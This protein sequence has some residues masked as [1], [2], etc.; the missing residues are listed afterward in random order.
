MKKRWFP[1]LSAL[2]LWCMFFA[3]AY[4]RAD[5]GMNSERYGA[6]ESLVVW[7]EGIMNEELGIKNEE[8]GIKN[9][10]LG[11]KNWE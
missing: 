4:A 7:G 6:G 2:L 8:L 11:I 3:G 10:E 1:I 5:A 9:E